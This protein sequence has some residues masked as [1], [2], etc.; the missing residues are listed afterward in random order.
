MFYCS[1]RAV[2]HGHITSRD[3]SILYNLATEGSQDTNLG[4]T[5]LYN[6]ALSYR[7]LQKGKGSLDLILE[8]NGEW[9]EKQE[10]SGVKDENSAGAT[11]CLSLLA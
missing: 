1:W 11:P 4:D 2:L 8:A 5:F 9:K 6:L 7:V 3:A 10:M